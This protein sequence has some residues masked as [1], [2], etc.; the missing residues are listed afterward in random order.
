MGTR[1]ESSAVAHGGWRQRH[2]A[3][4]LA[5][6]AARACLTR[7]GR[8]ADDVD[9]LLNVGIYR[10]RNLGEPALAALIQE[11]VG[12]N[13]EDPRP[14]SHGTFSFDLANGACGV[15]TALQVA[16]GFLRA[17]TI[18][19]ALV[20]ASDADPGHRLAAGFPF[21]ATGGALLCEWAGSG[22]LSGFRWATEPGT[23][24]L[25]SATVSFDEG[26]HRLH[27]ERSDILADVSV[28][29]AAKVAAAVLDE[30]ALRPL[31][32]DAVVLNPVAPGCTRAF[33]RLLG[34]DESRVVCAEADPPPH[35]SGLIASIVAAEE[36]G[37]LVPGHR[38][39][40]V[41]VGAG[42]TAGA[43]LLEC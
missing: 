34:V 30:Q 21:A 18:E 6:D 2:S 22:G 36:A 27:V 28:G 20:V 11:D 38:L 13:P 33:A 10:D 8:S 15:L 41:A 14:G 19:H 1:I 43:A 7:A 16:D 31:D 26:R 5:D 39:L 24:E 4:R 42:V 3:L 9:L 17:G 35:T 12:A 40:L 29:W 32:V 23:V 37:I 25:L